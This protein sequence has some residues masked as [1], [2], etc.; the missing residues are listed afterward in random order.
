[1]LLS[2]A[3]LASKHGIAPLKKYGQNFIFDESLCDKIVKFSQI[4]KSSNVLEIGPGP[5]GLTRSILKSTP[6]DLCVIE[7][8]TRCLPLL[9]EIK[10]SYP[11]LQIKHADALK[12][13]LSEINNNK[14]DIVANLPYNIG[15]QLLTNWLYQIEHVNSMTLMLQ[16]EVVDRIVSS[17]NRKSYGRLSIFCQIFCEVEKCFDVSPKAFYPEPKI[18]S[19]VVRLVPKHEVP[20]P[21]VRDRLE[22][23]TQAA[24]SGRRKMIKSSLGK[25]IPNIT[26][27]LQKLALDQTLRAEN[28][29]S[30]DYIRIAKAI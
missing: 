17:H 26:E 9:E 30:Q 21:I 16:K 12:V 7:T 14:I 29:S 2:I 8:D 27:I 4:D 11:I 15:S 10:L 20:E 25:I 18:W 19:S 3:K 13:S 5:A 28:L 24:F 22:K 6:Q 1:M 23:I